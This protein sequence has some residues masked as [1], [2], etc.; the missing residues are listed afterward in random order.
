VKAANLFYS[1]RNNVPA[2]IQEEWMKFWVEAAAGLDPAAQTVQA[3]LT[4]LPLLRK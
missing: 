4:A 2:E 1:F 3:G